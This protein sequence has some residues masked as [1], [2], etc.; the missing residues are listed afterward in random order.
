MYGMC[1]TR[2]VPGLYLLLEVMLHAHGQLVELV[3]LLGKSH[4]A[5]L[6]VAVVQDQVLLQ[7]RA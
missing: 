4:R 5:V 3:P 6:G 7:C 1:R 2:V